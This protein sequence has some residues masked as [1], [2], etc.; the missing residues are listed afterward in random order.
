M[1]VAGVNRKIWGEEVE[2]GATIFRENA[3]QADFITNAGNE[4]KIELKG[5]KSSWLC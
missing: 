2:V 5:F 1:V 4:Y 3:G